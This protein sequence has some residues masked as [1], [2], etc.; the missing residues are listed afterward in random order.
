M[1]RNAIGIFDVDQELTHLPQTSHTKQQQVLANVRDVYVILTCSDVKTVI[2]F[3]FS[4]CFSSFQ[5]LNESSASIIKR[6]IS[7]DTVQ[8]GKKRAKILLR[9]KMEAIINAKNSKWSTLQSKFSTFMGSY[10]FIFQRYIVSG[11]VNTVM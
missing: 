11:V 7:Q 4:T 3:L 1:S 9:D 8:T 5:L 2:V 6:Y 10:E